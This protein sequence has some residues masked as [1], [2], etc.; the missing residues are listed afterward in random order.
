[1]G[2]RGELAFETCHINTSVLALVD[3]HGFTPVET[4]GAQAG[5]RLGPTRHVRV[6]HH[7]IIGRKQSL[8]V[9]ALAV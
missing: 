3:L 7:I 9:L 8:R 5:R 1:M 2:F 6:S 4:L